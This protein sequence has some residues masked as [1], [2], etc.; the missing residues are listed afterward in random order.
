MLDPTLPRRADFAV[1]SHRQ[2]YRSTYRRAATPYHLFR[3]TIRT[4]KLDWR[5]PLYAAYWS[6]E[7]HTMPNKISN[8]ANTMATAGAFNRADVAKLID[9]A[10]DGSGV[11]ANEKAELNSVL[12][13]HADLFEAGAKLDLQRFLDPHFDAGLKAMPNADF[14]QDGLSNAHEFRIGS[15]PRLKDTDADG[16]HDGVEVNKYKLDPTATQD[17][18]KAERAPWTTTYWP[19]A[20]YGNEDGNPRTHLWSTGGAL[21]KLDKLKTS[22]GDES[23]AKALEFERKPALNWI[24]GDQDKGHY[25]PH[26]SLKENNAEMTT[27]VDF[28]GDG[29]LTKG[30][31]A[32][33]IN[34]RGD[35]AAV[36][37]RGSFV[38]KLGDET[39]TRKVVDGDNGE[40][41]VQYFKA[42]GTQLTADE[43][44]EVV[45]T[46]P[47]S[48]G[49]ADG[50]MGV[51]WWGS[52][53]KVALAGI[54]FEDPKR[55]VTVDGVT[56][57]KQDI[58]GL[59]TV[60]ADSQAKGTDFVGHRYDERADIVVTND[61]TQL[62]GK[63]QGMTGED[64]RATKDMWRW[65]GDYMV[66]NG[67]DK[68]VT[69]KL[70]DGTEKTIPAAE[71][72]HLAREDKADMDPGVF[73]VTMKQWLAEG[74]GAAMDK[75]AGSHVWNYNF[76]KFETTER[77]VENFNREEATGYHGKAG[78][79]EIRHYNASVTFDSGPT[80][81]SYWLEYKDGD[82]VNGG[83]KGDNPDFMWRPSASGNWNEHNER[84]PFVNPELVKEIYDASIAPE[85]EATPV[86][87]ND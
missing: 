21:D 6:G 61:G 32:D 20:G 26:S 9:A 83:W 60:V 71:I 1:S 44:K 62:S 27:G 59:L 67:F 78:D 56:F 66:T 82:I 42:D 43:A 70:S 48:D 54:L 17:S 63:I 45:L 50:N 16:L 85:E 73:H 64:F 22:R 51:G 10:K 58:R 2:Q 65:N 4:Q 19:M 57:T 75:D 76:S 35:F 29:K 3:Y 5:C 34:A 49:K 69:I 47:N 18:V 33:F 15:D 84:N 11:T 81:Y 39:L 38:P 87:N 53:D 55:D 24:V 86:E 12:T 41:N 72:K 23:G 36:V 31:K 74:R 40:K 7:V 25:I 79:G 46:N 77:K 80:N 8:L 28:D 52:C 37:D 13:K 68:D 30:V 14:D